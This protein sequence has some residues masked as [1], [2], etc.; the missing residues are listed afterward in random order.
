MP[1]IP[2]LGRQRQADFWVGGQSGLQSEF[3]DSQGYTGKPYLETNKQTKKNKNK[4]KQN[5]KKEIAFLTWVENSTNKRIQ[6][7]VISNHFVAVFISRIIIVLG[8]LFSSVRNMFQLMNCAL[9][10]I[11]KGVQLPTEQFFLLLYQHILQIG[12]WCIFAGLVGE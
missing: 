3:Q 2:V 10:S 11:K 1:L 4:T 9:N 5:E 7:Y 12:C 6:K 8:F